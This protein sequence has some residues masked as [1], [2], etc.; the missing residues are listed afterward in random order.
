MRV[1]LATR[2]SPLFQVRLAAAFDFL[3]GEADRHG[4]N[5]MLDDAGRRAGTHILFCDRV[6]PLC[7]LAHTPVANLGGRR[8][9]CGSIM[10]LE[11]RSFRL[12]FLLTT[13]RLYP[14]ASA[15]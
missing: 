2:I 8:R 12:A 1:A 9:C 14:S 4:Q 13:S 6:V 5:V 11:F 10:L 7:T 3:F 15:G